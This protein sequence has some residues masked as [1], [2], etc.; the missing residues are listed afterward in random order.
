[1][2]VAVPE[3]TSC[4]TVWKLPEVHQLKMLS[5]DYQ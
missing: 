4:Y 5:Q 2:A 1:M 3:L